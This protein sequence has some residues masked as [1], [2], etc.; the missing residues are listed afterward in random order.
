M[1][2]SK[3]KQRKTWDGRKWDNSRYSALD[4]A[5]TA[6]IYQA[7]C[8]EPELKRP[9]VRK[10]YE[11]HTG[12][13]RLA[14]RMYQRGIWVNM[15][16]LNFQI[17]CL[18]QEIEEKKL[19]FLQLVNLPGMRCTD[20][21]M[22]ALLYKRHEKAPKTW[23]KRVI[24]HTPGIRR[25]SLPDPLDKKSWT[26]EGKFTISVKEDALL[27]LL[28]SPD[29]PKEA[30]PI[31]DAFWDAKRT[32]KR[33]SFLTSTKFYDAIGADGR[34]RPGWN[35]CGTD[36]MRFSCK[37]PNVMQMEQIL[38]HVLGAQPGKVLVHAD[39]AQ[40]ELRVMAQVANDRELQRR[41]DLGDTMGPDNKP[42][43]D[44]YSEDAKDWFHLPRDINVKK[45]K[46][47]A[48]QASKIIHLMSQY[49]AGL[50]AVHVNVLA[51]DRSASFQQ[52]A[53]LHQ[54]F[55]STYED[56]VSYWHAEKERVSRQGFSEGR[57]LKGRR[58][59]ARMPEVTEIN[60]YP[61]QRT[62]AEMFNLETLE[63]EMLLRAESPTSQIIMQLHDAIDI[64]CD[65]GEAMCVLSCLERVMHKREWTI[66]GRT[67][68]YPIETK[69]GDDWGNL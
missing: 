15:E 28:S 53:L 57:V 21:D 60:N 63:L 31:I 67:R 44:V 62:A 5:K 29:C 18:E 24:K 48:R 56:T 39:K 20:D 45:L 64:E 12:L 51:E 2:D 49:G 9:E 3:K 65:A 22:R 10:L 32:V 8:A 42:L 6:R 35:S 40:L 66:E 26:D 17:H 25:F 33:K 69:V 68:S 1:T 50:M 13:S 11:V 30:V 37:E 59:Y 14:A 52:T 41:I 27:L 4:A 16:M 58:Y 34:L 47:K 23:G 54:G 61:I 46:N 38:R 7:L 55:L 43:S 36:T 19:R